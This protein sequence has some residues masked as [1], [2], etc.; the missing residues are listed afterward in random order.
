MN[1]RSFTFLVALLAASVSVCAAAYQ[2]VNGNE[3][4]LCSSP[5][6]AMT[7]WTRNGKCVDQVD[8]HGTHH[9]CIRMPVTN[10]F[11]TVTGQSNWCATEGQCMSATGGM[12]SGTCPRTNWCVCQWAFLSY[13]K[14]TSGCPE[15]IVCEATNMEAFKAYQKEVAKSSD[16]NVLK[17]LNCLID[18]CNLSVPA[19]D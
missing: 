8:D 14:E 1:A 9:I 4:E 6:M 18:K 16:P 15:T 10:N 2:N 19:S 17:A 5:G 13:V 7:G 3:L 11:C 12:G